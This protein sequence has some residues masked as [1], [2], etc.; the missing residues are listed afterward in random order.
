[1]KTPEE[2]DLLTLEETMAFLRV[3]RSTL[4]RIVNRG[5]L[6]GYKIARRWV[7]DRTELKEFVAHKRADVASGEEGAVD[8]GPKHERK[9]APLS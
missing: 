3:S 8:V 4:Y 2:S 1:M 7:F 9:L 5:E 6:P